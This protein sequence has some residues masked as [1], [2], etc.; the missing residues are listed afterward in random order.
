MTVNI[1]RNSS[2]NGWVV[3]KFGGTSVGKFPDKVCQCHKLPRPVLC[4]SLTRAADCRGHRAVRPSIASSLLGCAPANR[5]TARVWRRIRSLSFAR[6]G[7]PAR[8]QRV[9]RAGESDELN[10]TNIVAQPSELTRRPTIT[11]PARGLPQA[12]R[13]RR[14]H[15]CPRYPGGDPRPGHGPDRR[16]L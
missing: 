15:P 2:S 5:H 3:Q 10:P 8:R 16:D 4:A 12:A 14:R 13:D 9:P 7:V 6:R 11:Q 1:H